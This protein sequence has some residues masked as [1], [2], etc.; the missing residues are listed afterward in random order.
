MNYFKATQ[1]DFV[2]IQF[3]GMSLPLNEQIKTAKDWYKQPIMPESF[4]SPS[5]M[6]LKT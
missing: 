1:M 2:K 3:D 6:S 5:Y 4:L